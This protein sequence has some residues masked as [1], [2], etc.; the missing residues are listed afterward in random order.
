MVVVWFPLEA[1]V[2]TFTVV[3]QESRSLVVVGP[4]SK[5]L[6]FSG[7]MEM[8]LTVAVESTSESSSVKM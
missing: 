4:Q 8:D 2:L 5:T 6:V 3:R 7:L 1:G